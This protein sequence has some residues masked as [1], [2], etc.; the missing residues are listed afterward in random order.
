[1]GDGVS[2]PRPVVGDPRAHALPGVRQPPV[3]D[4]A[5]DE[6]P[7]RRPQQVCTRHRRPH[8]DERH[9]VLQLIAE[10]VGAARLV[11]RRTGP[12]AAGERL[13]Q[14]PAVQHDVH[15]PVRGLHLDR[16]KGIVPVTA[17]RGQHG[18]EIFGAVSRNQRPCIPR[19][20]GLAEEK[21]DLDAARPA[22]IRS[23][24]RSAAQGS[25]PAPTALESGSPLAECRR[26]SLASCCGR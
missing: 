4:V 2:E 18:V 24:V 16:A 15:R 13:I 5:L 17:D 1:M 3:L 26:V 10:A 19:A 25:R 20:R 6:L 22:A 9:A 21:D 12:D 11:E 23:F 7:R 14:Q 8:S